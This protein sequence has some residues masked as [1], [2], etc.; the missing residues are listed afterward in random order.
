MENLKYTH[1]QV[2]DW[3]KTA[4]QKAMI[5]GSFNVA[6]FIYQL[7]NLDKLQAASIYTVILFFLAIT[8]TLIALFIWLRIIYPHLDNEHKKSKIYFQHIA[9]AYHDDVA[10]GIEEMQEIR[11]DEFEKDLASQI[12]MVSTRR[13]FPKNRASLIFCACF[14]RSRIVSTGCFGRTR[15]ERMIVASAFF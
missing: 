3:I 10:R 5:L 11:D 8:A 2:I 6:G 15:S 7:I 1:I 9:N 12:I 14:S 4:D 13:R